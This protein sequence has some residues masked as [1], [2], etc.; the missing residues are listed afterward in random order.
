MTIDTYL[1][2]LIAV[3]IFFIH[4]PGPSQLLFMA[5]SLRFGVRQSVPTMAGDLSANSLQILVAGF[6]LTGIVALSAD[7]FALVKWAGV[8]YL[9]WVGVRTVIAKPKSGADAAPVRKGTLFRQGFVTSAANPYAVIFFAALFPQFIQ[10]DSMIAPQIAILGITYLVI[11][12]ALLIL[13]GGASQRV[14]QWLGGRFHRWVNRVSGALM[15]AAAILLS[16]KD[17]GPSPMASVR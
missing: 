17:M 8:A 11:D 3:G 5:N 2:Y 6:G 15:I 14:F 13:L 12:G 7:F 4:P 16:F 1:G 10:P 9:V